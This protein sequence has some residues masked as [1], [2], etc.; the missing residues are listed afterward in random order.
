M[1]IHKTN[2]DNQSF[3]WVYQTLIYYKIL[4]LRIIEKLCKQ[5][6]NGY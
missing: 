3:E 5:S 1:F 2:V 4:L 6:K